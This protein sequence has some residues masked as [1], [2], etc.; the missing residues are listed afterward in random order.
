MSLSF[1]NL[2]AETEEEE[3]GTLGSIERDSKDFIFFHVK[4]GTS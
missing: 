3:K 2:A 4:E 1:N